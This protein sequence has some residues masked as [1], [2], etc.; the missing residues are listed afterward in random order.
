[1]LVFGASA[2]MPPCA[3][4]TIPLEEQ[5]GIIYSNSSSHYNKNNMKQTG[6]NLKT[7]KYGHE[8]NVKNGDVEKRA[9]EG[10]AWTNAHQINWPLIK[11]W[12]INYTQGPD[13]FVILAHPLA[14][15]KDEWR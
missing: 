9:I 7:R 5:T 12:T 2:H 4:A 14:K 10:H 13:N 6:R 15:H 1:M 8:I 3:A 11:A